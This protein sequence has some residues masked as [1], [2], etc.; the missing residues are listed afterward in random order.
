MRK[1]NPVPPEMPPP[2][3]E[4]PKD[5]RLPAALQEI[6][7]ETFAKNKGF[8]SYGQYLSSR[9]DCPKQA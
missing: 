9:W 8:D 1:S 6:V 4:A 3:P 7:E 5:S 2:L